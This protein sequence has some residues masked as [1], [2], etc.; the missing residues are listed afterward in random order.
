MW[1]ENVFNES[2]QSMISENEY[3]TNR[4]QIFI[5]IIVLSSLLFIPFALAGNTIIYTPIQGTSREKYLI[6]NIYKGKMST[7]AEIN[8]SPS[9]SAFID[10]VF[11]IFRQKM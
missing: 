8:T 3:N 7:L 4:L 5:T 9:T 1:G 6:H 11:S 2:K 10:C